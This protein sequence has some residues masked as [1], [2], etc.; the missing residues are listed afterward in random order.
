VG[1]LI[2]YLNTGRPEKGFRESLLANTGFFLMK[3]GPAAFKLLMQPCDEDEAEDDDY[4]L[5]FS[6]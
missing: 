5:S 4:L 1:S 6:K 2:V 3:K